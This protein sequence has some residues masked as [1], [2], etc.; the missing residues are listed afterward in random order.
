LS[1]V[2]PFFSDFFLCQLRSTYW[3]AMSNISQKIIENHHLYKRDFIWRHTKNPYEIMI[4]EFMLQRTKADQVVPV[5]ANFLK[6]YPDIKSLSKSDIEDIKK[7]IRPL[8]LHWRS[9]HFKKAAE[10]IIAEY[11]SNIPSIREELL[12]IPGIG[13]YVASVISAVAFSK[14]TFIVDSNIAR[15]LNRYF[16][17]ALTGEIRRNKKIIEL[18]GE[19][20]GQC[21][22]EPKELLFAI[23]DFSAL[24]CT[25]L[26][27]KHEIC[28]LKDDCKSLSNNMIKLY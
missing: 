10:Y 4:A 8:G 3:L 12:T 21:N 17:L 15:V 14:N 20:F 6:K 7:I 28:P 25:P 5:Y 18:S 24:V 11:N 23:I 27:P 13:D 19:L 16:G 2:I 1:L 22:C 9:A 26:K